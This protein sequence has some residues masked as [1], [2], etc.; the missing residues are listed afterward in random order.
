MISLQ[1]QVHAQRNYTKELTI[2]FENDSLI[3]F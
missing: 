3:T 1:I 2:N